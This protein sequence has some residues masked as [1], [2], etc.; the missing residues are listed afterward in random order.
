MGQV[1]VTHEGASA[2]VR[3][4]ISGRQSSSR[5]SGTT[6]TTAQTEDGQGGSEMSRDS[7]TIALRVVTA[8]VL[9]AGIIAFNLTAARAETGKKALIL[10]S[11]VSGGSS[12]LEAQRA[13]ALGFSPIDVVNS[14]TW[15][16]MTAAQFADYQLIIIGDPN[17]S[18]LPQA[19]SQNATALADAVMARSG[20]NTKV[21]NRILIGTDPMF[22]QG[23]GGQKLV[24]TAIEFAGVQDGASGLY[25]DF[26]CGDTDYDANGMGDGQQFLLPLLTIDT[27][28]WTQN[29]VPPCGG[30]VSL[31]SNAAQFATLHTSDLQGWSCSVHES[32][33]TFPTDWSA[34]AIATDT[35]TK[36]TCGTDV[37]TGAAVCGEA[38]ILVAGTGIVVVAPNIVLDPTTATNP[39]GT[40][41][42]VT[43]TVTNPDGTPR[44]GQH[45]D[46]VVTGANAGASGTCAPA[47]CDTDA[48]GLVAFTYTGSSP[49]DDTINASI[50]VGGSTQKATA[51]K[52]WTVPTGPTS[53]VLT[54]ASATNPID[55][56][57]CVTAL[58]TDGSS[59][60]VPGIMV[61]FSV[62]GAN[63]TSSSAA[64]GSDGKAMLCYI[65]TQTGNDTI[66]AF[67]DTDGSGTQ[68][69]GEPGGTASKTWEPVATSGCEVEGEARLLA[70]PKASF[71]LEARIRPSTGLPKGKVVFRDRA[72]GLRFV[73]TEILSL[74]FSGSSAFIQGKGM[75]NGASVDFT[76]EAADL[77]R[78]R[79]DMFKIELTN[80]YSAA[81]GVRGDG[82]EIECDDDDD[83]DD[84][85]SDDDD[86]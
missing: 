15:A 56:E 10:E 37:D 21:G 35:P 31:I 78:P 29:A 85:D 79:L 47:S 53:L 83:D 50:T 61:H 54:P 41:H 48:N 68:D 3:F 5:V 14:A 9:L 74:S 2:V 16:T 72:A 30:S 12:S 33:P 23:R 57:H 24:D 44:S 26:S 19:V 39:V 40:T 82:I 65:G 55:V 4:S 8:I 27:P 43:A 1:A 11:S 63:S 67:A 70:N 45:V 34:L 69:L 59:V 71:E 20:G 73:S 17:C 28:N 66:E 46:F 52:T 6:L 38:Y 86:D 42:A 77:G 84:D 76:L 25:L 80:G 32:F 13:A 58:V 7:R 49:G 81:G 51:S 62:T 22:H 75:V 36:P 18:F 60:P 64:T